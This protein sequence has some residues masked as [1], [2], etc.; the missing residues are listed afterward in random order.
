M[1]KKFLSV[2]LT[3]VMVIGSCVVSFADDQNPSAS[4]MV[5]ATPTSTI[6]AASDIQAP[7]I[8]VKIT[9]PEGTTKLKANPYKLSVD[10][11][12]DK[13]TTDSLIG[14]N[15][16]VT[17]ESN[18]EILLSVKGGVDVS[19]GVQLVATKK[20]A[21]EATKPSVFVQAYFKNGDKY[22]KVN[23]KK[24][25]E[26]AGEATDAKPA[27]YTDA[28]PLVYAKNPAAFTGNI[29]MQRATKTG[30]T[31]SKSSKVQIEITGATGG[32][33]WKKGETEDTDKFT[34]STILDVAPSTSQYNVE[35]KAV[36]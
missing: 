36:S 2:L 6:T 13:T 19:S 1:K 25:I 27:P 15:Y 9:M 16:T 12:N 30:D 28:T 4:E 14:V 10:I 35:A 20:A 33:G 8:S 5:N 24:E 26:D 11:G 29:V 34:A 31:V 18:C 32:V 3:G 23:S 21:E 7:T 17:N 22:M